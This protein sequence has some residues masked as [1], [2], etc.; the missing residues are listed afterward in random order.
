MSDESP[1]PDPV[2]P[3]ER[4]TSAEKKSR[5][6]VLLYEPKGT[7]SSSWKALLAIAVVLGLVFA[8]AVGGYTSF[9]DHKRTSGQRSSAA[10]AKQAGDVMKRSAAAALKL[11]A[12]DAYVSADTP[13]QWKDF[14]ARLRAKDPKIGFVKLLS[15]PP[16]SAGGVYIDPDKSTLTLLSLS[17]LI[18]APGEDNDQL[19]WVTVRVDKA[20]AKRYAPAK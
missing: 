20:T 5:L 8:A 12:A 4:Y 3:A 11:S 17:A 1:T 19:F 16:Y 18:D 2:L 7:R 6:R 13:Q 9:N 14:A 10:S 15:K